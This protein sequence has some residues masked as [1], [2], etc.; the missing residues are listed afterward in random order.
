M[1]HRRNT[2]NDIAIMQSII[3]GLRANNDE[4]QAEVNR[5]RNEIAETNSINIQADEEDKK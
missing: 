1:K 5:L 2:S 3:D 4:L